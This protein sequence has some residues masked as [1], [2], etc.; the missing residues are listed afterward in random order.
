MNQNTSLGKTPTQSNTRFN[1]VIKAYTDGASRGNPGEAGAGIVIYT[2]EKTHNL[3][4]Y[5]GTKTNNE[6]EYLALLIALQYLLKLQQKTE[7]KQQLNASRI[8]FRLDSLLVVKQMKQE[9]KIKDQRM[10]A[11]ATQVNQLAEQLSYSVEYR[12]VK[13]D[14]NEMADWLANQAIDIKS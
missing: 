7:G 14:K 9:W 10:K 8:I 6:A 12:H 4:V 11:F 5:L 3:A 2:A 13:R 1:R